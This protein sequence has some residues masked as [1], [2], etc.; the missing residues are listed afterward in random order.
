MMSGARNPQWN[1]SWDTL[2]WMRDAPERASGTEGCGLGVER[3][4]TVGPAGMASRRDSPMQH[5]P[6]TRVIAG[7]SNAQVPLRG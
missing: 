6:R 2:P 4:D 5:R 7:R 3:Y 1:G